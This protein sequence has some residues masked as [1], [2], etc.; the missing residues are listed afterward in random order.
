MRDVKTP[1]N[2]YG[3]LQNLCLRCRCSGRNMVHQ[4]VLSSLRKVKGL[5]AD[6]CN[7]K[8]LS[9]GYVLPTTFLN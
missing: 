5:T 2:V 1:Y 9:I 7:N 3:Q 8:P 6:G 4:N